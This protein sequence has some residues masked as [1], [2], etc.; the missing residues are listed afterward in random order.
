MTANIDGLIRA[1][2]ALASMKAADGGIRFP[3][4]KECEDAAQALI[5]L[6]P[7]PS[8]DERVKVKALE[9]E[10]QSPPTTDI[11]EAKTPFGIYNVWGTGINHL[12]DFEGGLPR[13]YYRELDEA[14]AA[15]Q[16][17]YE[18]RIR[19]A[20]DLPGDERVDLRD[21]VI[22]ECAKI[23]DANGDQAR[24]PHPLAGAK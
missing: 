1:A 22:E 6:R 16:K 19:S 9:W 10:R 2:E 13:G 3:T 4:R 20:L 17:D 8:S 14:K 7:S 12:W 15:A 23:A 11:H 21:S 5:A 18:T 24:R